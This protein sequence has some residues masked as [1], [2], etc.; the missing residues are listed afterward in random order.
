[1]VA[2]CRA[3]HPAHLVLPPPPVAEQG[4]LPGYLGV[5]HTALCALASHTSPGNCL[6]RKPKDLLGDRCYWAIAADCLACSPHCKGL[7]SCNLFQLHGILSR[8]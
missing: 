7:D 6:S 8:T 4:I 3:S 1:M 2:G 5:R